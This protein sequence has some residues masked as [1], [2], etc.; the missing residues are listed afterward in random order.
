MHIH[1]QINKSRHRNAYLS[2]LEDMV[3]EGKTIAV[4]LDPMAG[5]EVQ[6]NTARSWRDRASRTF[7]KK[8]STSHLVEV[9]IT[10]T[11]T[12]MHTLTHTHS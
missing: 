11:R 6:I 8:N 2:T 7:M 12:H 4:H 9:C 10:H 1:T 5:I 3:K